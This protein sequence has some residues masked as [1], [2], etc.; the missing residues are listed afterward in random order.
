MVIQE[1]ATQLEQAAWLLKSGNRVEAYR[2]VKTLVRQDPVDWRAWW[3]LAHAAPNAEERLTAL[4]KTV[5]FNPHHAK[6]AEMLRQAEA[7]HARPL[8]RRPGT[9]HQ[10]AA[11]AP[12]LVEPPESPFVSMAFSDTATFTEPI[13]EDEGEVEDESLFV[14]YEIIESKPH[15]WGNEDA[16]ASAAAQ[17]KRQPAAKKGSLDRLVNVAIIILGVMVVTGLLALVLTRLV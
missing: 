13:F 11:P 8:T 10:A 4:R 16:E 6:A 14:P 3:G 5:Q 17:A 9:L 1:V 7:S 12:A 2:I 15:V